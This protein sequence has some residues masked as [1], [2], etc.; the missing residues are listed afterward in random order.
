[1]DDVFP[2]KG[3]KKINSKV[4][5][6]TVY[7]AAEEAEDHQEVVAFSCPQCG[8]TSAYCADN[9]G[10]TCTHCKYYEA[11]KDLAYSG[12]GSEEFEF[13]LT[14]VQRASQG[15]GI[16]RKEL[17]CNNCGGHS[18][19]P[20]ESLSHTCPF[21]HSHNVV[22]QQAPQDVLRPRFLIPIK[23]Q[24]NQIKNKVKEWL[25]NS[26][27]L[28]KDL[29]R[30]A[31]ATEFVPIYIPYWT[32]DARAKAKWKAEVGKRVKRGDRHVTI[33]RWESGWVEHYFDDHLENGSVHLDQ[34]LLKKIERFHLE[35]LVPYDPSFLAGVSAQAYE[36]Q[37]DQAWQYARKHMR[38]D[39]RK[40]S[41]SQTS[42][43]RVRNF[44]MGLS[45]SEESWRYILLPFL[46]GSYEY[47]GKSY[48]VLINGQNRSLAGNRPADW[49]KL[50][51]MAILSFLPAALTFLSILLFPEAKEPLT[52]AGILGFAGAIIF[53]ILGY[54]QARKLE[55]P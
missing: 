1:M 46:I 47:N 40:R 55:N 50:G 43:S 39:I 4:S 16:E 35:E 24:P 28:P 25:G 21:C 51:K 5:G 42:T 17:E 31:H 44:H 13:T 27:L 53:S 48:Q 41:L 32:F 30:L 14:T 10:L 12:K 33:W 18:I 54:T 36:V 26:W 37:L 19:L 7:K 20:P 45:F 3:Y 29:Q 6:I 49:N 52:T 38:E 2:P 23:V 22:Q 34:R 15:W 8:A 9:G 11:P